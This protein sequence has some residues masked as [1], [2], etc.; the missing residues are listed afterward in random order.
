MI[1]QLVT[2]FFI[3]A[4]SCWPM[5]LGSGDEVFV[6]DPE[7]KRH[8][9]ELGLST[10]QQRSATDIFKRYQEEYYEVL[11]TRDQCLPW[12]WSNSPTEYSGYD[13]T[14]Q[15]TVAADERSL[16]AAV[17][18]GLRQLE[19]RYFAELG[20]LDAT[21]ADKA[22][23]LR[24]QHLRSRMLRAAAL[25]DGSPYGSSLDVYALL[26]ESVPN[27]RDEPDVVELLSNYE[28]HLDAILTR[29]DGLLWRYDSEGNQALRELKARVAESV[30]TESQRERD[31]A[32]VAAFFTEVHLLLTEI[33]NQN[34]DIVEVV[35]SLLPEEQVGP[36]RSEAQRSLMGYM[37]DRNAPSPEAVLAR[38]LKLSS[39]TRDQR[40]KLLNL[41]MA[42]AGQR[43][44]V[45][46]RLDSLYQSMLTP[47]MWRLAFESWVRSI[48]VSEPF[49][50][51][52]RE[53]KDKF[54]KALAKW[55]ATCHRFIAAIRNV[56]TVS[57][58][59]EMK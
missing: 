39:L 16:D 35:I 29:L 17:Q 44:T 52:R 53:Q 13:S 43:L 15:E 54:D 58:W 55:S 3:L 11:E 28:C 33:R 57:Q 1:P 41:R 12:I 18:I 32:R 10:Q 36:L 19:H 30:L 38:S 34:K 56:L 20:G 6:T 9:A 37:Y 27:W 42:V 23:S 7:F 24:R 26:E 47:E 8:A 31:I 40:E 51:P 22:E 48:V 25:P 45:S 5:A 49:D 50:D 59:E 2:F 46:S 4:A 21:L 14:L